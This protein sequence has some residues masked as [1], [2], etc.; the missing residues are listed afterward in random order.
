MALHLPSHLAILGVVEGSQHLAQARCIYYNT[1]ILFTRARYG[2]VGQHL[3]GHA[4]ASNL[5]KTIDYL[6]I[7][8]SARGTLA[9]HYV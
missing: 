7:N 6:K 3:D 4:L 2:C 9:L 8:E 5:T 1:Q